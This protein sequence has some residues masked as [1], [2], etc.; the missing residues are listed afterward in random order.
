MPRPRNCEREGTYLIRWTR[1]VPGQR[2]L[3]EDHQS[4]CGHCIGAV[5]IKVLLAHGKAKVSIANSEQELG[6]CEVDVE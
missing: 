1:K 6:P 4:A 5:L 2:K 3:K